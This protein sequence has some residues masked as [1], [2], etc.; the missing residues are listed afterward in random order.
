MPKI[1]KNSRRHFLKRSALLGGAA[2]VGP[3]IMRVHA[4]EPGPLKIGLNV[5]TGLPLDQ[6]PEQKRQFNHFYKKS[7]IMATYTYNNDSVWYYL[8]KDRQL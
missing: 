4:A 3:Q 1:N 8:D 6:Q 2:L 7:E 5:D